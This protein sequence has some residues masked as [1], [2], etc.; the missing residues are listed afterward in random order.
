MGLEKMDGLSMHVILSKLAPVD[1][2]SFCCVSK[3]LRVWA[4]DDSIWAQ[5]CSGEL[6][7]SSPIDPNGNPT[8]SFK[9][10][11][12]AW[13][14]GFAM[15]PWALV[16]R[17]KSCWSKLKAWLS[18][19]F[20]EVLPTLRR[21]ASEDEIRRFEKSLKIELP[22]PTRVLYRFCDGQELPDEDLSGSLPSSLL[23]I[24]GGYSIY[25]HLVNVFLLPLSQVMHETRDYMRLIGLGGRPCECILVAASATYSEKSFFLNCISGQL[26]VG[27][28]NLVKDGEML[29]CVPDALISSVHDQKGSQQQDAM[30]LWLEEHGR[31]LQDGIIGVRQERKFRSINLFPE[32]API[33]SS[34]VTNGV[35]VRSSA[36]FVP[37]FSNLQDES[38]KFMFAYS[39]R[40]SLS[41]DGCIINGMTFSS[42]QLY[43]RHWIIRANDVVVADPNGEAVI[44]KYPLLRPGEEEFVYESW[45]TLQ[46]SWG[47]IEGSFTFVPGRYLLFFISFF[48]SQGTQYFMK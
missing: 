46:A 14:D 37:E 31:R 1:V 11:Y 23:G 9:A 32:K 16:I 2:A 15:Y 29:P 30:L 34:A 47:S 28:R 6:N 43:W 40:L 19:N 41:P 22:L 8:A 38:D 33:C 36:V 27:T 26:F 17:A 39:I 4:S 24:I 44:G 10:A 3:R 48:L 7:L 5:F 45:T 20:P 42:C 35:K 18:V 12:H 21:G 25:D 13:R